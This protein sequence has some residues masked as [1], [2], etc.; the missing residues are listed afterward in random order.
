MPELH[1]KPALKGVVLT[2]EQAELCVEALKGYA[3]ELEGTTR[4]DDAARMLELAR[5]LEGCFP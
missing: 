3:D 4:G 1:V 2:A 5:L